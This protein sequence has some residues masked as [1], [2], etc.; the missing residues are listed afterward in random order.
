MRLTV[1]T[2]KPKAVKVTKNA[3][4]TDVCPLYHMLKYKV[5]YGPLSVA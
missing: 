3:A 1:E 5:E 2:G 4:H